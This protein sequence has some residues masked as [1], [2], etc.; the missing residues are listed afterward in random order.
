MENLHALHYLRTKTLA[1][2]KS[3]SSLIET[4]Q[5]LERQDALLKEISSEK[6]ALQRERDFLL[7]NLKQISQDIL[8]LSKTYTLLAD[9]RS[10][11]SSL[12]TTLQTTDYDPLKQQVDSLRL[13]HNLPKLPNLS[14][15]LES[16]MASYLSKRRERWLHSGLLDEGG[17]SSSGSGSGGVGSGN[18]GNG[19]EVDQQPLVE[20]VP[21]TTPPPEV[22][23][24]VQKTKIDGA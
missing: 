24:K 17:T 16:E 21:V 6:H 5:T 18:G 9:S 22:G 19:R 1:L 2:Q 14:E 11:T 20:V 4:T 10:K 3:K 13:N 8:D 15:E 12:L 7:A 23:P